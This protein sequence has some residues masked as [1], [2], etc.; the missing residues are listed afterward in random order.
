MSVSRR[1]TRLAIVVVAAAVAGP[2]LVSSRAVGAAL[3][4]G[5]YVERVGGTSGFAGG[6]NPADA[7]TALPVFVDSFATSGG[8]TTPQLTLSFPT[9]DGSG[10]GV[11]ALTDIGAPG[12]ST[13]AAMNIMQASPDGRYFT[14][15]G[16][17]DA[18]GN[19][20]RTSGGVKT[21]GVIDTTTGA[22][23]TQ[24]GFN[25][26]AQP[27]SV[28]TADGTGFWF[29]GSIN[30]FRYVTPNPSDPNDTVSASL[31]SASNVS[32]RTASIFGGQ[33][34]LSG[35]SSVATNSGSQPGIAVMGTGTPNTA[36]Q[37]QTYIMTTAGNPEQFVMLDLSAASYV[38]GSVDTGLDTTYVGTDAGVE[39]WAF[40]GSGWVKQYTL[41][42]G[43][44]A[45]TTSKLFGGI[46]GVT[47]AGKDSGGH[48]IL[49]GTTAGNNSVTSAAEGN[50]LVKLVDTGSGSDAWQLV[51]NSP[52]N[53]WFRGLQFVAASHFAGDTNND[54]VVD[55]T[56]LNNVL[57]NFGTS[58]S[59]NPG[60]DN[61][62]G[63]VDLTDLN[64]V[65]NNF[66]STHAASSLSVVPEP[67]S[68]SVLAIGATALLGRR[69]RSR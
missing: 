3:P 30:G 60:D 47:Y 26:S 49:Y 11:R 42:G 63:V 54:G 6:A 64:N 16:Y 8:A 67:A 17:D 24:L 28:V 56:D 65:L 46:R 33:L 34:F 35:T 45:D 19:A 15:A 66:G 40:D 31:V 53:T 5:V 43:L 41:A 12:G 21:I 13:P 9:A 10:N 52:D 18:A 62:D 36:T 7:T 1:V 32:Q 29:V 68:V 22:V 37:T 51:T 39:K 2:A 38:N 50:A 55:L 69:R 23:S 27:R 14:V 61:G 59:G 4:G 44:S 25:S 20:V 58:A 57:N 48:P